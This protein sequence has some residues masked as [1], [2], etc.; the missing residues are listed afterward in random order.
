MHLFVILIYICV[1]YHMFDKYFSLLVI[2]PCWSEI[3]VCFSLNFS[4]DIFRL[5]KLIFVIK[6]KNFVDFE[7]N[8]L[9]FIYNVIYNVLYLYI[10]SFLLT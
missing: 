2:S 4:F 9:L 10:E 6:T 3:F 5:K 8:V 1:Y 7:M